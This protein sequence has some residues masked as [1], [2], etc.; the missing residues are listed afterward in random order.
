MS[1]Q[2]KPTLLVA[3]GDMS[4]LGGAERDL[5]RRLPHLISYFD[6]KLAT[7]STSEELLNVCKK[8]LLK[9]SLQKAHGKYQ[10]VR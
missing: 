3:K 6:V 7:L 1:K 2:N 9:Y 5:I 8:I 4:R 10:L